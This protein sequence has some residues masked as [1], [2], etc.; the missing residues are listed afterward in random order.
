MD[1][2]K[3]A[4]LKYRL[5]KLKER[6]ADGGI[7]PENSFECINE[8][9]RDLVDVAN[10]KREAGEGRIVPEIEEHFFHIA[11]DKLEEQG[12][13]DFSRQLF[14][15]IDTSFRE[16]SSGFTREYIHLET[17]EYVTVSLPDIIKYGNEVIWEDLGVLELVNR[18]Q[19]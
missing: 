10:E 15:E 12:R 18:N 16:I 19:L 7:S 5:K 11:L 6:L 4:A 8:I 3:I 1:D 14:S 17:A 2:K 9:E 13:Y